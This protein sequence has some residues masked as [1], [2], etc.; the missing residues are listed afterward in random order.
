MSSDLVERFCTVPFMPLTDF[1]TKAIASAERFNIP[2]EE[3]T[4]LCYSWG[5]GK[6]VLLVHGWGSRASH[7]APLARVL[8]SSGFKVIAFDMPAHA[9]VNGTTLKDKS[10]MFE[11]CKAISAVAKNIE[12]VYAVV[13]HSLG[14]ASSLFTVAGHLALADY[15]FDVEKLVLISSPTGVGSMIKRFC[16]TNG[17]NHDEELK[18]THGLETDFNFR[19][20]NYYI[21]TA[22]KNVNA[23]ILVIHDA[24]DEE[25]SINEA[26]EIAEASSETQ[27]LFTSGSGHYKILVNRTMLAGVKDFL[28]KQ[29][30]V[31]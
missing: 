14:A 21:P 3:L 5:S 15:E 1:D 11:F 2:F 24:D 29:Q 22:A 4:I 23:Q 18:L 30:E 31:F 9:S 7:L 20:D 10:N 16:K 17:L 6:T 27:T 13:G 26:K 8:S 12:P 25:I 28:L 19:I